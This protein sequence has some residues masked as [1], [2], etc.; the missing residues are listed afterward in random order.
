MLRYPFLQALCCFLIL[1]SMAGGL[2]LPLSPNIES[3]EYQKSDS[4]VQFAIAIPKLKESSLDFYLVSSSKIMKDGYSEKALSVD[5]NS[6][7]YQV[8]FHNPSHYRGIA[9]GSSYDVVCRTA[10][11][12]NLYSFNA[13]YTD[14]LSSDIAEF[15]RDTFASNPTPFRFSFPNRSILQESIRNLFFHVP[16]WFTMMALLVYSL[17]HSILYLTK[18]RIRDDI[19]AKTS[20]QVAIYFGFLGI[21]TGMIWARYTW[22]AFWTNDPKLNGAA[23]GMLT[24][25]A[26][27]ILRSS[28]EDEIKRAKL[29]AVYNVFAFTIYIVFIWILPRI[30][31]SLHPGNGGNPGFNVYEQDD[32]MRIFF[33]PAV[34]GWI[35]LA[36]WVQSL[37][38]QWDWIKQ[39]KM[40]NNL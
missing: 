22:G 24:Y 12:G 33:Y 4:L 28:I 14:T 11:H 39:S 13:Y 9:K 29:A 34:V 31:D 2:L 21:L 19:Q 15:P 3:I 18:G 1:W 8:V 37:Y 30:N 40:E 23:I 27:F 16:M 7:R 5:K 26:Y 25:L 38:A 35:L 6:K 36:F 17:I 32:V 20:A 10:S